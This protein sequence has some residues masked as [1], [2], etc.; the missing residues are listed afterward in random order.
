MCWAAVSSQSGQCKLAG[1]WSRHADDGGERVKVGKTKLSMHA[2][3]Q[4][5]MKYCPKIGRRV[6][7]FKMPC[8]HKGGI[9]DLHCSS[10]GT[11]A[12]YLLGHSNA[13]LRSSRL[14]VSREVCAGSAGH[15]SAFAYVFPTDCWMAI[16]SQRNLNGQE[17]QW[18]P[19]CGIL[20]VLDLHR[21]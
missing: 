7:L 18:V 3:Q 12:P 1:Q 13:A 14:P 21:T 10:M 5:A 4:R 19:S 6:E 16:V 2:A 17:M 8:T 11:V 20:L 9:E 15:L